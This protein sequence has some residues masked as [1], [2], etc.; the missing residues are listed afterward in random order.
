MTFQKIC[1]TLVFG[2]ALWGCESSQTLTDKKLPAYHAGLLTI[3]SHV[4]IPANFATSDSDPGVRGNSQVD[5]IKMKEGNLNSI[6]FIVYVPQAERT[7]EGYEKA[8][9]AART[10]FDAIHRMAE[11]MYPDQIGIAR[12]AND[13]ARLRRQ[14]KFAA[15]I[16]VENGYAFGADSSTVDEYKARGM[17]Y[18]GFAHFGHSN[19]ADS[20][21]PLEHLNNEKE[22]HGGLS[23]LGR[24]LLRELNRHGVVADVSHSSRATTLE[25]SRLSKAPVIASHSAVFG[26]TPI[27]R[28]L[29]D[30][31]LI[32]IKNTDGVVQIVAYDTYLKDPVREKKQAMEALR[33]EFGITRFTFSKLGPEERVTFRARAELIHEKWP[34][35]NLT[36]FVNHIDY[37]VRLIGIDHVGISSDFGG[38]GGVIGWMDASETENVTRALAANGYNRQ[39]IEKLWGGN[40]MRVMTKVQ[41][42]AEQ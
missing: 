27:D 8:R 37:A 23:A 25:V 12:T 32:A 1:L 31:E 7:T 11:I 41:S 17:T 33:R 22:E 4:D 18:A 35:A 3:D 10:K 38:G 42:L 19:F 39:E 6:F 34:R 30:E 9:M 28:N 24:E 13:I 2:I 26:V 21:L 40:L 16:G 20:S 36:D 14:D 15:L 29:T 5:L